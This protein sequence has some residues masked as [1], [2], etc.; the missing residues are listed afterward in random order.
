VFGLSQ[1]LLLFEA[2]TW[3]VVAAALTLLRRELR[4]AYDDAL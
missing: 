2:T 1:N 4:N 3:L